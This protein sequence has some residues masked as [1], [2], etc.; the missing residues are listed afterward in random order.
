[1]IFLESYLMA[2]LLVLCGMALFL[3]VSIPAAAPSPASAF[4]ITEYH[5]LQ[6][7][8][9]S[10][11]CLPR[12]IHTSQ[13]NDVNESNRISMVVSFMLDYKHCKHVTPTV[14]YS[15][16]GGTKKKTATAS[17]LHFNYTS[18]ITGEYFES[19]WLYHV[20]LPNL[21]ADSRYTYSISVD[22]ASFDDSMTTALLAQ[23]RLSQQVAETPTL[24]FQTPPLRGS[25]TTIALL[26]DLGQTIESTMTMTLIY[27][28]T[29]GLLNKHPVSLVMIVGDMSYADSDPHRWTRWF[30]LMEPLFQ[31]LPLHVA[32]GN[33]EIECDET[34]HLPFTPY[35]YYFSNPNRIQPA[36]IQPVPSLSMDLLQGE[37]L[38]YNY[39][40]SFYAYNHGL[41]KMVVLNSYTHSQAGSVQYKW[42]ER[43][44]KKT[45][46]S[47]TPWLV[48]SFHSPIYNTFSDHVDETQA[49][50]MKEAMEDLFVQYK[51]NLII[52]GHCHAY[53]RTRGVAFDK[54]DDKKGPVY[55]IVGAGGNRE[56]HASGYQHEKPE[57]WIAK[58][59]DKE[60]GYGR[61]HFRNATHAKWS[62]VRD[63]T[64]P[65]GIRDNVWI[66]NP[67]V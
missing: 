4:D 54:V 59:D 52:S 36:D 63:G 37:V 33:H 44:L 42:L 51:V 67:H 66:V 56:G 60:F 53:M 34:T 23:R 35:E 39:G 20:I 7:P 55:I 27:R 32:A 8:Y 28:A 9:R 41:M 14:H 31:R 57:K 6:E 15:R 19:D 30:D 21:K 2:F 38:H 47:H 58:R 48:V 3:F 17:P 62:W 46:R 50:E 1:M 40:N 61:L 24:S 22:K 5:A 16:D 43:E 12:R 29:L 18:S 10:Y 25:P 64:V 49:V 45:N 65:D 11:P 13:N 26:G